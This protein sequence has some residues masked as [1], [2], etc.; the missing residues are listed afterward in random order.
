MNTHTDGLYGNTCK[1]KDFDEL[2]SQLCQLWTNQLM[3]WIEG[4]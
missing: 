4:K 2:W 1:R 3:R